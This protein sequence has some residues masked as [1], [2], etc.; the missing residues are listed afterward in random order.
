MDASLH[1]RM[2]GLFPLTY[3]TSSTPVQMAC[4]DSEEYGTQDKK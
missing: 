1:V 3:K 2:D 4:E